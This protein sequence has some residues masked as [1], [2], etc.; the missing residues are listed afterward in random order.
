M[1]EIKPFRGLRFN[2]AVTGSL[3]AVVTPPYDVI[4]PAERA[5]LAAG[6]PWN[7]TH[8]IL[9]EPGPDGGSKYDHAAALLE[10]WAG[11]GALVRD[12]APAY[13][14]LRQRFTDLEGRAHVRHAF[15][16]TV[17][18]PEPGEKY[19]LGHERTFSKP[20]EDRLALTRATRLNFGAVFVLYS[21]PQA[22]LGAFL[23]QMEARPADWTARTM[24]GAENEFWRVDADPAVAEFFPGHTLYIADGHHRFQTACAYRDELRAAGA[25]AGGTPQDYAL[26][27][28]VAFEDPG[29]QVY[30]AHRVVPGY[31]GFDAEAVLR[32]LEPWFDM[33]PVASGL[34]DLVK[35]Q[36]DDGVFGLRLGGRGDWLLRFNRSDRTE[37]LGDDRAAPWRGLDVALLHRGIFERILGMPEGAEYV[38]EKRVESALEAVEGGT[39]AMAFVLKPTR[40]GQIRDC[41]EAGEPMPQKSTYFFPK[42]P[43]G[44]V[45]NA[46]Y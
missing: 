8:V 5:E 38:Y 1:L 42:L 40:S 3:D 30:A 31:P 36:P 26:M 22:R 17:K 39:A 6:S 19:I 9:P 10:R 21:D 44:G 35:S 29:L 46:L 7:M 24:D 13:Y 11:E 33:E 12:E 41:A 15:Y 28:F 2:S 18:L 37:L 43:T 16:A 4:T 20:V 25:P 34:A 45:L 27:G 23:A 32:G 14:L